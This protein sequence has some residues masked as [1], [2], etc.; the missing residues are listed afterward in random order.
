MAQLVRWNPGREMAR[1][2][3]VMDRLF[4]ENF[5]RPWGWS[6]RRAAE[7]VGLIPLDIHENN[8][9]YI[10]KAPMPGVTV[11]N[12]EITFEAGVL[13]VRGE[14]GEEKEVQGECILQERTYG[15][16]ARSVSLPSPV[17]PD[18]IAASL[19]DGVLAVR[20]PKAEEV[21]PKKINVRVE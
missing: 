6:V 15:K 8:D 17:V 19:K 20:I 18:K 11:D 5:A 4:E 9:E 3:D 13:T 16:F 21:K 2:Q 14:V 7:G 1:M 10:V 12:L